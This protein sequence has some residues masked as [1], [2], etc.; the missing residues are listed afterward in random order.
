MIRAHHRGALRIDGCRRVRRGV[1][2]RVTC[3]P[4]GAAA[5]SG[6]ASGS[7][8]PRV[9]DD[10]FNAD[11]WCEVSQDS[12]ERP[13]LTWGDLGDREVGCAAFPT[14]TGW[15]AGEEI[16]G[17]ENLYTSPTVAVDGNGDAWFAWDLL[18]QAIVRYTHTYVSATAS[19]ARFAG[20]KR[21]PVLTWDL[22][23]AA[24]RSRWTVLR[25]DGDGEF[26][27]VAQLSAGA[28]LG[29]SY[30]DTAAPAGQPL[31]YRLR[32]ECY[33]KRFEWLS[34]ESQWW[35]RGET[36]AARLRGSNPVATRIELSIGGAE[37]GMLDLRLYDLQGRLV[38][39]QRPTANGSAQ[40]ALTLDLDSTPQRL[41]GGIYFL[42]ALDAGGRVSNTLKVAYLR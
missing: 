38:L 19:A 14:D 10:S 23:T 6:A 8:V 26:A 15:S 28:G 2:G 20:S 7:V 37:G 25:A 21:M 24:P 1:A 29:I 31:R 33:D 16:P 34:P 27:P 4:P 35:P 30:T 36:L 41:S 9:H 32:R 5:V 39:R 22:S 17:S 11:N 18:R 40:D 3:V 13:V 12:A 42:K